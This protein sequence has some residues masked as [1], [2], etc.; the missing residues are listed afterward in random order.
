MAAPQISRDDLR[1]VKKTIDDAEAGRATLPQ[2]ALAHSVCERAGASKTLG[3][4]RAH[5]R[6]YTPGPSRASILPN[7]VAG[8][9]SGSIVWFFLGR[10]ATA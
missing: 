1:F 6:R 7:I 4:L 2:L 3:I 10:R 8:L 5:I 9:I